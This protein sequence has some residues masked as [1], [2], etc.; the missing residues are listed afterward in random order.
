MV[1][2]TDTV[3]GLAALAVDADAVG[4]IFALKRRPVDTLI[5]A[6]V[7]DVEQA[8]ELLDLGRVGRL[9]AEAFWPGPLTI[10]APRRPGLDLAIGDADTVGVRCP[11]NEIVRS[12]ARRVGPL[13]VTS[14]NLH[15]QAPPASAADIV[16]LFP[17]TEVVVADAPFSGTASTVVTIIEGTVSVV[18]EGAVT[19][20]DIDAV[21]G[22]GS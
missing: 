19:I 18:R 22:G 2:P 15:G 5:A 6:L 4:A 20:T 9:L 14:A 12:V 8:E 1:I 17:D 10:V 16:S 7:A 13:A 11:D 3:Y 21:I